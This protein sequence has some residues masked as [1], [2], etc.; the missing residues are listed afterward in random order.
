MSSIKYSSLSSELCALWS[1]VSLVV[2]VVGSSLSFICLPK[3]KVG[4]PR[5]DDGR[6]LKGYSTYPILTVGELTYL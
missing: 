2:V 5:I 3:A 4:R 1:F 6:V